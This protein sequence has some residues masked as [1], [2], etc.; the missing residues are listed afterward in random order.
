VPH[1]QVPRHAI[2]GMIGA[3]ANESRRNVIAQLGPDLPS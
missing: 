3:G 1:H 2:M